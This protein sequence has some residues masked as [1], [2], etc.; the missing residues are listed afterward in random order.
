MASKVSR[1]GVVGPLGPYWVGFE[2]VLAEAGY[3]RLSA[4]NLVQLM[5]HLS[6]WLE[7]RD[8]EGTDLVPVVVREYLAQRRADGYTSLL[9]LRGLAPLLAYLRGLGVAPALVA[10]A[11][12]GAV[13]VVGGGFR[14]F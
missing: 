5:Q 3:T 11:A 13:G 1:V 12:G 4:A 9:S 10:A 7:S 14:R 8:L 6:I 2:A